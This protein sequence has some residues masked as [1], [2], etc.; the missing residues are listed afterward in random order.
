MCTY[1]NSKTYQTTRNGSIFATTGVYSLSGDV[2]T[3]T[4]NEYFVTDTIRYFRFSCDTGAHTGQE[5][6]SKL[7][8]TINEP[9]E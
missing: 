1:D 5:D 9:I 2:M 3:Y 6:G 4:P 7:I 8:I